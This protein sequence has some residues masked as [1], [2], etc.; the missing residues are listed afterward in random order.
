MRNALR[1]LGALALALSLFAG[2]DSDDGGAT[3]DC[4][5]SCQQISA[6]FSTMS[7]SSCVAGCN[8]VGSSQSAACQ[9]CM[10]MSC[11]QEFGCCLVREC[12]TPDDALGIDCN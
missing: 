9:A 11:G 6:C 2:C 8:Q 7:L 4:N 5:A 12:G 1:L 10:S 3:M